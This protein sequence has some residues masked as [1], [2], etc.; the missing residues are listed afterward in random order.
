MD[1]NR[2]KKVLTFKSGKFVFS[3]LYD[4]NKLEPLL[5][6]AKI[7]YFTVA[8]LPILP[9]LISKLEEELIKKSIFGTA[10][11]EGNPLTE[12]EVNSVLDGQEKNRKLLRS[13]QEIKNL[14]QVYEIIKATKVEEDPF[15]LSED[16]IKEIHRLITQEINYKGNNPGHYRNHSVKV[17][18]SEHGGVYKPPKILT[19]IENLMRGFVA[20]INSEEVIQEDAA[21]RAALA[22]Y[23]LGLL[24]PFGNGNGRT[25]RVVEAVLLKSAGINFV[26][27]MLSNFYYR[28]MDDYFWAFSLS[29]KNKDYQITPFLEFFLKGLIE[30]LSEIKYSIT[31]A[32]KVF[33]VQQYYEHLKQLKG[34][35]KR[36]NDLLKILISGET[37][38]AF[39]LNEL[40]VRPALKV[41]YE[42]VS[43]RTAR[44]DLKKLTDLKLLMVPDKGEYLLNLN[45]LDQVIKPTIKGFN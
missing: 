30:A 31:N 19:D 12:E 43:E 14:K 2:L 39:K 41:L 21:I 10:A 7:L 1:K 9:D 37:S 28:N 33:M 22:H 27:H 11:I 16:L 36:Q 5:M 17:G 24:H 25:A 8:D 40:F 20:W 45:V 13:E 38:V 4:E 26:P 42:N 32:I 3:S 44:R 18:N 6:E 29:E 15:K 35:T 34:I 23:H